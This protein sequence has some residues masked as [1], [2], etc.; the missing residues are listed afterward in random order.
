MLA[1]DIR[2][3]CGSPPIAKVLTSTACK[4][5]FITGKDAKLIVVTVLNNSVIVLF[6]YVVVSWK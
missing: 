6:V 4:L 3:G 1:H 2:G 5:F